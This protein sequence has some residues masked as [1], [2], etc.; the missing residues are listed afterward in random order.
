MV[1]LR[2]IYDIRRVDSKKL[3]NRRQVRLRFECIRKSRV[4]RLE[5]GSD[6]WIEWGIKYWLRE[7]IRDLR[8]VIGGEG[9][10]RVKLELLRGKG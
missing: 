2:N 7:S 10:C 5:E 1:C 8:M 4:E 3:P 6:I 9:N